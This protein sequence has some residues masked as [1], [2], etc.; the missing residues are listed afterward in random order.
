MKKQWTLPAILLV[1]IGLYFLCIQFNI[2]LFEDMFSWPTLLILFGI[3]FYIHSAMEREP[4]HLLPATLFTGIG[5][6]F[7]IGPTLSF[8]PGDLIAFLWI[9]S[10]GLFFQAIKTKTG[11]FPSLVL[12]FIGLFLYFLSSIME[13]L[14]VFEHVVKVA[15]NYWPFLFILLGVYLLFVRKR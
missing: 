10:I 2:K 4:H 13:F 9:T 8:W 7:L 6:H 14:R 12:L 15:E 11:I 3:A 1:E 5:F